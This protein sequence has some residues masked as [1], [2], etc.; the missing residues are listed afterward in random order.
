MKPL[1][2]K[3]A[4]TEKDKQLRQLAQELQVSFDVNASM[5]EKNEALEIS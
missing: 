2:R 4:A 5:M 1:K 3:L